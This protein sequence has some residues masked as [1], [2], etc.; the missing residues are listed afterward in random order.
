MYCQPRSF[1]GRSKIGKAEHLIWLWP[2]NQLSCRCLASSRGQGPKRLGPWGLAL[3]LRPGLPACRCYHSVPGQL[4]FGLYISFPSASE[5]HN[6]DSQLG[7]SG[8][9]CMCVNNM[10]GTRFSKKSS[11]AVDRVFKKEERDDVVVTLS[12]TR[13]TVI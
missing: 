12:D 4:N 7:K 1:V 5:Y 3:F 8:R 9:R 10:L 6:I 13:L 11:S 2:R